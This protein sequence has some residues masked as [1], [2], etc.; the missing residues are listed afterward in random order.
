MERDK[1]MIFTFIRYIY[2]SKQK[3]RKGKNKTKKQKQ[4][5]QLQKIIKRTK[6][7]F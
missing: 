4:R 1:W 3:K 5:H 2:P 6:I 7:H